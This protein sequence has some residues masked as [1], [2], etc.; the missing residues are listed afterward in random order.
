MEIGAF[1]DVFHLSAVAGVDLL[2]TTFVCDAWLLLLWDFL[3]IR[4]ESSVILAKR[5]SLIRR[6]LVLDVEVWKFE[7]AHGFRR[8]RLPF[9]LDLRRI[10]SA[11]FSDRQFLRGVKAFQGGGPFPLMVGTQGSDNRICLFLQDL[12]LGFLFGPKAP[13]ELVE[14]TT[15]NED[16]DASCHG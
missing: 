4:H 1:V 14:Q 13:E 3:K 15:E 2:N 5:I 9:D 12:S 10:E 6:L 16:D 7:L 11:T 8:K